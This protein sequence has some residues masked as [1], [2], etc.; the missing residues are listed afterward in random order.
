MAY[1]E[2]YFSWLMIRDNSITKLFRKEET[3]WTLHMLKYFN[4]LKLCGFLDNP[5]FLK[6]APTCVRESKGRVSFWQP[7]LLVHPI[8]FETIELYCQGFWYCKLYVLVRIIF[9]LAQLDE[10]IELQT[11][12][13]RKLHAGFWY[14]NISIG[15]NFTA[16]LATPHFSKMPLL[17]LSTQRVASLFDNL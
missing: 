2:F 16:S 1:S 10:T 13:R 11:L 14:W 17:V 4:W 3:T 5:I 8:N 9:Q 7:W 6:E 12:E 15:S